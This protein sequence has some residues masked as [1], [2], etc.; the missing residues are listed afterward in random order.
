M[1]QALQGLTCLTADTVLLFHNCQRYKKIISPVYYAALCR[2]L[3]RY[4]M[5]YIA[6]LA[7]AVFCL[8]AYKTMLSRL[9]ATG[10]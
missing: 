6:M 10:R 4:A 8:V 5:F 1:Q 9:S 2:L 3:H 7:I